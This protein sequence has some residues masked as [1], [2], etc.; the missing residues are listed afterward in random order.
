MSSLTN[1]QRKIIEEKKKIAQ[2]KLLSKLP[3]KNRYLL[4]YY[5]EYLY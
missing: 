4:Y 5:I 3:Q 1:E 2:K